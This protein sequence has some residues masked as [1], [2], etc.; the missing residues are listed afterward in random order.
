M[1]RL[2]SALARINDIKGGKMWERLRSELRYA[3]RVSQALS[4]KHEALVEGAIERAAD[5]AVRDGAIT[6]AAALEIERTLMPMQ[7]DCKKYKLILCGHAH[8]DMNWMWRYD[9]TVQVTLDTFRTVLNLMDEFPRFTFSQSQASVYRIVEEFA[10]DMLD[11]IRRRAQEGRWE[12]TASTWVE[13]DRNMPNAESVARHHLYTAAYLKSLGFTPSRVDFEPDTFGHHQNTPELLSQA[14]V[15]YYYHCRGLEGHTLYRWRA[16]SGAE[17]LSYCEPFWYNGD[18]DGELAQYAPEFCEKFGVEYALRVYGVGDHGGGPTRR[19]IL[20]AIDM[21]SW[22]IYAAIEFGT[23]HKFFES[24]AKAVGEVP[25]VDRELNALFL[26]CY[27]T[28]TRIKKGNRYAERILSE[29]EQLSAFA[30]RAAD[31]PYHAGKFAEG[32]RSVLFNQFHDILPGSGVT[33]TR[34][35]A[36]GLYQQVYATANSARRAAMNAI[37]GRI[38]TS[39]IRTQ[40]YDDDI[41]MGAGV[42]YHV[43]QTVDPAPVEF[44]HGKTRVFH[45]FNSCAFD[46]CEVVELTVWDMKADEN[47]LEARY[48]QGAPLPCQVIESG[49]NSYWG[50]DYTRLL[51]K[52]SVPA[53]GYATCVVAPKEDIDEPIP[54]PN[55]QRVER[56]E[57]WSIENDRLVVQA[58]PAVNLGAIMLTEKKSGELHIIDGFRFA[59]EDGARGMT[60]WVT[61]EDV[62]GGRIE[63][64]RM[65]RTVRGPLYNELEATAQFGRSSEITYTIG[66]RDGM[67]WVDIKAKVHWLEPGDAK[68]KLIPQL[69]FRVMADD[70][71]ASE[72]LYDIPGGVLTRPASRQELPGLRFIA[73]GRLA[74]MS[75]SKYGY[76]GD[77][78][79][80]GV[81]LIRSSYDP[82]E[83]PELGVHTFGLAVGLAESG[84]PEEFIRMA[85]AFQSH[86]AS[87]TNT[88]HPGALPL[89]K[90]FA[91]LESGSVELYGVKQ[92]EDGDGLIL[93]GMELTGDGRN[94]VIALEG[95]IGAALCDTHERPLAPLSVENGRISFDARPFGL[96]TIRVKTTEN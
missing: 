44:G 54:R 49:H 37:A 38:D 3:R 80:M 17:I 26:G 82:D 28:Q 96:F 12:V 32:W 34:E 67:D 5:T 74:L 6:D 75:D 57:D 8:I 52:A 39:A 45:L 50:H 63:N 66:L 59:I 16:P 42:G 11:E 22:P 87:V 91:R 43:E 90:S 4:G 29:A 25:V 47:C 55:D 35:Y 30:R 84:K 23:F 53:M 31:A 88:A 78:G 76:R 95:A 89:E 58:D 64:I 61:G 24:A 46:R 62:R 77:V 86:I 9:E 92:A 81:T 14:G 60:A 73:G 18:I 83:Y 19:D 70:I 68:E 27:T 7:A 41:S 72:Y 2:D 93:R 10:P 85:Q 33:D 69:S 48:A 79:S 15:K 65:R 21:Q 13:A 1:S 94:T 71:E 51:V 56:G 40:P 20:R 36:M